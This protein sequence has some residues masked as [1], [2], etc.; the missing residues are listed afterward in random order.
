M[1]KLFG[2]ESYLRKCENETEQRKA[3]EAQIKYQKYVLC[4]HKLF[5]KDK[6]HL[7]KIAGKNLKD[8]HECIKEIIKSSPHYDVHEKETCRITGATV[9]SEEEQQRVYEE[10]VT[11]LAQK[12][13]TE[14]KRQ[15]K[16]SE[17]VEMEI[18]EG[19]TDENEKGKR[20]AE[21][22]NRSSKKCQHKKDL[23]PSPSFL[24]GK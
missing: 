13:E 1:E 15:S 8:L 14:Q 21:K 24:I 5:S 3:V 23:P 2:D 11:I 22:E 6:A 10:R 7:F 9:L 12:L 19:S 4:T 18:E 16:E 17:E 20:R